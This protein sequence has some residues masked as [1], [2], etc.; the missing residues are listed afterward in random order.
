[1]TQDNLK[2]FSYKYQIDI[3]SFWNNKTSYLDIIEKFLSNKIPPG[4]FVI[5]FDSLWTIDRDL[6]KH[7]KKEILEKLDSKNLVKLPEYAYLVHSISD[8]YR[9]SLYLD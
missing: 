5:R 9:P 3:A 8:L 4:E 7:N 2:S 1:M 6:E